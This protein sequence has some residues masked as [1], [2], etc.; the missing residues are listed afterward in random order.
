MSFIAESKRLF[1]IEGICL[2]R[3]LFPE[4]VFL[5]EDFPLPPVPVEKVLIFY[6]FICTWHNS[7]QDKQ[8]GRISAAGTYSNRRP[9][10]VL[11]PIH[12]IQN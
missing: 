6:Q 3:Q 12:S 9:T 2:L 4:Q 5:L 1:Q 8:R 10:G 11:T 7:P